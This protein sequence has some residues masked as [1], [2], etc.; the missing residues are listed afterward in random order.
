[1]FSKANKRINYSCNNSSSL[2]GQAGL[3]DKWDD[4]CLPMRIKCFYSELID[5]LVVYDCCQLI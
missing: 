5:K 3:M 2:A 4:I 1:M